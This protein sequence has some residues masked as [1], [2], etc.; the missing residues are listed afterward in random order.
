[1]PVLGLDCGSKPLECKSWYTQTH[2][3][4]PVNLL[5]APRSVTSGGQLYISHEGSIYTVEIGKPHKSHVA[6]PTSSWSLLLNIYPVSLLP[7]FVFTSF[8]CD[9]VTFFIIVK[10][11]LALQWFPC[12]SLFS[13]SAFKTFPYL[14]L[15]FLSS[16]PGW[17]A[18]LYLML[19][20]FALL[21]IHQ[22]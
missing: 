17:F 5:S 8:H 2:T 11:F 22:I 12:N 21:A 10:L 20:Q 7:G 14:H 18:A 16:G 4:W 13:G 19:Y 1:M 15:S 6:L 3:S 9:P